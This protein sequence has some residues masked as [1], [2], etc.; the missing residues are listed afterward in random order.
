MAW[1]NVCVQ[2]GRRFR[3]LENLKAHMALVHGGYTAEQ[4]A[5]SGGEARPASEPLDFGEGASDPVGQVEDAGERQPPPEKPRRSTRQNRELNDKL[6]DV[7]ELQV[8]RLLGFKLTQEQEQRVAEDGAQVRNAMIGF[9]FD[10]EERTVKLESRIW[11]F[12]IM[13]LL[14][15][16][17]FSPTLP[18]LLRKAEALKIKG[19]S[20]ARRQV[21]P[22]PIVNEAQAD[23]EATDAPFGG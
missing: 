1:K 3:S 6:N 13:I 21:V 16:A 8:R 14:V 22:K 17:P 11:R 10:F 12:L 20:P 7:L 23:A 5:D 4:I 19:K 2:C 9:E 15:V 18:E